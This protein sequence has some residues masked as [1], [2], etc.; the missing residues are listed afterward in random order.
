[1]AS[2]ISYTS[3]I[4]KIT[5]VLTGRCYVGSS[6]DVDK[7]LACH[8]NKLRQNKHQNKELQADFNKV[9]EAG[10]LFQLIELVYD[11]AIL[12]NRESYHILQQKQKPYNQGVICVP[13]DL[14]VDDTLRFLKGLIFLENGC[15]TW[16]SARFVDG[17]GQH[18]IPMRVS[19][20]LWKGPYDVSLN[21]SRVCG[22]TDCCNPS[23]GFLSSLSQTITK[24]K[25]NRSWR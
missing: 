21:I 20:W 14:T 1:M 25:Q 16:R 7:R 2:K 10:F 8:L 23:H 18:L 24:F 17:K 5:N 4:Y 22:H 9:G 13:I 15:W 11:K 19:F 3:G 6:V 12:F